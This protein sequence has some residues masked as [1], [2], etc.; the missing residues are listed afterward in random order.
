[1]GT[2]V[3]L[4]GVTYLYVLFDTTSHATIKFGISGTV[5]GLVLDTFS[6]SYHQIVFPTFSEA[7]VIA[8]TVW[9]SFAYAL[10][11]VIPFIFYQKNSQQRG[12]V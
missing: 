4:Y 6:L 10:F 1:M 5:I 7:Q 3:L 2:A 8:F 11:L 12:L 9:M